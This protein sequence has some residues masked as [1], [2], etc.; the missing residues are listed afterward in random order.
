MKSIT[1]PEVSTT[2][3]AFCESIVRG[4]K[5]IFL[6]VEDDG[7][8]ELLDCY[9]NVEKKI[10]KDGG[11]VQYGWQVILCEPVFIEAQF[12]A[13][14]V[15]PAGAMHDVT[16][17]G[18]EDMSRILFLPDFEK[19]YE[20]KQIDNVQQALTEDPLITSFINANRKYFEATNQG[21][22]AEMNGEITVDQVSPSQLADIRLWN[23]EGRRL[24]ELL[25]RKYL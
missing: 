22:L 12:H 19:N 9:G 8:G 20:G 15:D 4:A 11:K 7:S 18:I 3:Q 6:E 17:T 10:K 13:V 21:R 1:P 23:Y 16:P 14:W 24:S 5:P 2:V 25:S